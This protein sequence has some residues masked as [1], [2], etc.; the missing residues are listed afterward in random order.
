MAA[1]VSVSATAFLDLHVYTQ[2]HHVGGFHEL[3]LMSDNYNVRLDKLR[4]G[5]PGTLCQRLKRGLSI[6]P[7]GRVRH[8][9]KSNRLFRLDECACP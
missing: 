8:V 5:I 1:L 6:G 4:S 7:G 2:F 9:A 3:P